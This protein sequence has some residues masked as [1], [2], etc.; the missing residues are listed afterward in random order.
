MPRGN[1]TVV[2]RLTVEDAKKLDAIAK[3]LGLT[4]AETLQRMAGRD[5]DRIYRRM[6]AG[7]GI[8]LGESGA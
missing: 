4:F 7:E 3:K 6:K 2:R 8:E 5:I 1:P